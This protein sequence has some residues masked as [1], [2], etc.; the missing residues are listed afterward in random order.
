MITVRRASQRALSATGRPSG[1]SKGGSGRFQVD[2][3]VFNAI[4]RAKTLTPPS[5]DSPS[6]S[7]FN[8]AANQKQNDCL[9]SGVDFCEFWLL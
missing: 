9:I 8:S 2:L 5:I 1:G 4:P 6:A 3:K 7:S